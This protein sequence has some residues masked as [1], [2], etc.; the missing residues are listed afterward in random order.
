MLD[1]YE[2]LTGRNYPVV[3]VI[4]AACK[5]PYWLQLKANILNRE[6]I[7]CNVDEAVGKGAAMLAAKAVGVDIDSRSV[8]A[9]E[10]LMCYLPQSDAAAHYQQIFTQVYKPLYESKMRTEHLCYGVN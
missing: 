7:A 4:G 2:A 5:N 9:T 1:L 6:I 8:T 10:Q 3:N